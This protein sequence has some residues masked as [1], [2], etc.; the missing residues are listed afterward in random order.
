MLVEVMSRWGEHGEPTAVLIV[1]TDTA[2][3]VW[4]KTNCAHTHAIGMAEYAKHNVLMALLSSEE[5]K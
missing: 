4:M 3:D 2:G 5:G 1:Y